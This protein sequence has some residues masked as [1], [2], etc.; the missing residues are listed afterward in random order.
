MSYNLQLGSAK[1]IKMPKI[2]MPKVCPS[3]GTF[4]KIFIVLLV[5]CILVYLTIMVSK[6]KYDKKHIIPLYVLLIFGLVGFFIS[7]LRGIGPYGIILIAKLLFVGGPLIT[8]LILN[9]LFGRGKF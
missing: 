2:N 6:N 7:Y 1:K 9:I 3:S 4:A 5:I 8:M